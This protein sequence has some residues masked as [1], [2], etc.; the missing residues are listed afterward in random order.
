[1]MLRAEKYEKLKENTE[2]IIRELLAEA[3]MVTYKNIVEL[4]RKDGGWKIC[5][6]DAKNSKLQLI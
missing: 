2:E 3:P 1:M 5:S 6:I 4:H